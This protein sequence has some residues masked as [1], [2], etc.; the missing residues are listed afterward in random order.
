MSDD[1]R[2]TGFCTPRCY[3]VCQCS[4]WPDMLDRWGNPVNHGQGGLWYTINGQVP[5]ANVIAAYDAKNAANLAAS[6]INLAHPGTNDAAPGFAPGWAAGTGWI[7]DGINHY[8]TTGIVPD[9][10]WSV[11][12]R[13]SAWTSSAFSALL[14]F[15]S[16]AGGFMID[17]NATNF[18]YFHGAAAVFVTGS[19]WADNG[20]LGF[21]AKETYWNGISDG[22]IGAG[23][24]VY[25][26]VHIC[27]Y[28]DG[29]GNVQK[30]DIS[31]QAFTIHNVTWSPAQAL[32]LCGVG[33]LMAAL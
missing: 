12:I 15:Y 21:A 6:Y 30:A 33:G 26:P 25:N 3:R 7:F 1:P 13:F 23:G 28:N 27:G 20:I 29:V 31:I 32:T 5:L 4:R 9:V 22:T 18:R 8:L 2:R 16:L 14:G 24:T 10:D 11:A 19:A 17:Q